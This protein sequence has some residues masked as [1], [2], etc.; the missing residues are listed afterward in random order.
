MASTASRVHAEEHESWVE[1]GSREHPHEILA[2]LQATFPSVRDFDGRNFFFGGVHVAAL[3]GDG[4]L[5]G[6]GDPRRD[7]AVEASS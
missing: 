6:V 3:A 7:G 2:R 4:T 5:D 1:L